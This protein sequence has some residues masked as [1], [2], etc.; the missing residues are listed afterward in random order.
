MRPTIGFRGCVIGA[1]IGL[2]AAGVLAEQAQ[3]QPRASTAQ[4]G[5]RTP[6][7]G[8]TAAGQASKPGDKPA[9]ADVTFTTRLEK[10]A[11]WIGDQFHYQIFVDHSPNIQF[12]L[13][14]I[15]KDT[16]NLDPLRVVSATASTMPLTNGKERLSVD[17]V[18]SG[19]VTGAPE[20][21]IPQLTLFYFRKEGAVAAAGSEGA[22]AQSLT[23]PGPVVGVRSTLSTKA[24]VLRDA[25]TVTA[26]PRGRWVVAA[27]GWSAGAL[28][29]VGLAVEGV[30]MFR[31]RKTR[32]GPDPRKQMAAI[33]ARWSE[34]VPSDFADAGV[35]MDFY[36]RSYRDLKE[37]LGCLLEMPTEGLLADEVRTE[38]ARLTTDSDLA[39]RAGKILGVCETARYARNPTELN[40]SAARDV[41]ENM[42]EIFQAA[43]RM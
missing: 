5:S 24:D 9:D 16:V 22:A 21:Q 2:C 1:A 35:V 4:P 33:R 34:S 26:W 36:G 13:E 18:L 6:Q 14:N 25:V 30:Q 8:G 42:Q 15:N 39:D 32:R 11:I 20:L 3:S 28:L 29:V 10:T 27:V 23:I 19:F 12:I 40:G 17:L 7:R 41:A 31:R 43:S 37:Y 38:L